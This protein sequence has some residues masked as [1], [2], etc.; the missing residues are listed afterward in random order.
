M[1]SVSDNL[2]KISNVGMAKGVDYK[3]T[4]ELMVLKFKKSMQSENCDGWLKAVDTK[5]E[6]FF[7]Y[8]VWEL[9][10][11][12]EVPADA[13]ILTSMWAMKK[14]ANGVLWARLDAKGYKQIYELHFDDND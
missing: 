11:E 13:K 4:Q 8:G 12:I 6:K 10:P 1:F 14:K 2:D 5:Y 7:R 9:V 3:N